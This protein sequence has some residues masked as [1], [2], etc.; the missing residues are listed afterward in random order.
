MIAINT[1]TYI[2][3][4]SRIIDDIGQDFLKH[5]LPDETWYKSVYCSSKAAQDTFSILM[6]LHNLHAYP[7]QLPTEA[8]LLIYFRCNSRRHIK[9]MIRAG[10]IGADLSHPLR[11]CLKP[12]GLTILK[13]LN[14]L[15]KSEIQALYKRKYRPVKLK[16]NP[17]EFE[18]VKDIPRDF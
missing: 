6:Y 5:R 12:F 2:L 15:I 18:L 14:Y 11:L 3:E 17:Q 9:I 1:L 16:F 7:E 13:E 10:M 4:G 8:D